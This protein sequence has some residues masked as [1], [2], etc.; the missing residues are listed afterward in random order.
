NGYTTIFRNSISG[1]QS[2]MTSNT[3]PIVF[4]AHSRNNN[5][6]GNVLGTAGYH[7][8]YEI[9]NTTSS[10]Q[11]AIYVF[12]Y[13]SSSPSSLDNYD[14]TV[15]SSML[16]H[17]NYDVVSD[18]VKHCDTDDG[19]GCQGES[20]LETLPASLYLTERPSWWGGEAWPPIGPDVA[21]YAG[22]NPAKT[23]YETGLQAKKQTIVTSVN[24]TR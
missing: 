8:L 9:Q 17:M 2:G 1:W 5:I 24:R 13:W 7:N 23:R 4:Q 3:Y 20:N 21:G 18:E 22:N 11:K 12:G 19:P 15:Y 16:R 6:V 14:A 10:S